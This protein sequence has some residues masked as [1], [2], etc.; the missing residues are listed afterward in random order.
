M[1][2]R[3]YFFPLGTFLISSADLVDFAASHWYV[4]IGCVISYMLFIY[5]GSKMMAAKEVW[6]F[7]LFVILFLDLFQLIENM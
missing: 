6:A 5:F 4:S 3:N 2:V 7:V 1:L